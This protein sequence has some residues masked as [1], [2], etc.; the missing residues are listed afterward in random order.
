[1]PLRCSDCYLRVCHMHLL[2]FVTGDSQYTFATG[3]FFEDCSLCP[4]LFAGVRIF[5]DRFAIHT[6]P[7]FHSSTSLIPIPSPT[8]LFNVG[9]QSAPP[10]NPHQ[11]LR[12]A[13]ATDVYAPLSFPSH[14]SKNSH[15]PPAAAEE[16]LRHPF[17]S[18]DIFPHSSISRINP[19]PSRPS[20]FTVIPD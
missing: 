18:N 17:V 20:V 19:H 6:S 11:T 12:H 10:V 3:S 14:L 7:H 9:L 2:F 4:L 13:L 16:N 15:F 1:M 8:P 5:F